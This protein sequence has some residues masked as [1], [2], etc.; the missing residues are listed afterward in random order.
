M[1]ST[2]LEQTVEMTITRFIERQ[3]EEQTKKA[4]RRLF[5]T[6]LLLRNYH[7]FKV[8]CEE[9]KELN[10]VETE[11]DPFVEIGGEYLSI[12]SL[13]RSS[14]RT[15]NMMNFIDKM[16]EFYKNDCIQ[17]GKEAIRKYDT[18][19]HYY[20]YEDK[21]TFDDI[22]ELH[23]INERTVR[24]DLKEAVHALSVLIFGIDGLRIQ[25]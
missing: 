25:L 5:N 13:T 20:I 2:E 10:K 14:V 6:R 19:M 9:L 11:E 12:E 8:R 18:L 22:A 24:R 4:D 15:M 1:N 3:Q 17:Q 23:D 7:Q 16:L 21:K